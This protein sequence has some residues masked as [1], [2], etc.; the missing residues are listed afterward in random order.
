MRKIKRQRKLFVVGLEK[1][2]GLV[3]VLKVRGV[4]ENVG[5]LDLDCIRIRL[6]VRVFIV[7]GLLGR[8][9]D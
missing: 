5:V 1:V 4:A 6:Q 8:M 3:V 9:L 7:E 2:A